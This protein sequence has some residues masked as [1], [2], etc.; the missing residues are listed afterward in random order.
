[1]ASR[2]NTRHPQAPKTLLVG[3]QQGGFMHSRGLNSHGHRREQAGAG[4]W[5]RLEALGLKQRDWTWPLAGRRASAPASGS[6]VE[7]RWAHVAQDAETRTTQGRHV[8]SW[9]STGRV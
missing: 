1:M 6:K 7:C 2:T 5:P 9:A 8:C 4:M 3:K